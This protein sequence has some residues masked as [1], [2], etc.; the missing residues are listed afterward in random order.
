M[1]GLM[2]DWP[3]LVHRIIDHAA[4]QH[5]D[6]TVISR[7]VEG[8]IHSTSYAEIH[9][10]ALKVAQRLE[11]DGIRLGDRVATLAWNTFRHLEA[12]YGISGIGAVYHTVNPRLFADQIVWIINHAEDRVMLTD[13]TFVPLLEKLADRLPTIERYVVLTDAA[14]MPNTTLRNAVAYEDWINGVD[15]DFAWKSVDENTA[16][17][18]CYTSGTTGNPKGVL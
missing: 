12:W 3:L 15:G 17:G 2:Q 4:I 6:R 14:H 10:R 11:R 5:A 8:P 13:L 9:R 7:S 16:C 1:Q 18:M